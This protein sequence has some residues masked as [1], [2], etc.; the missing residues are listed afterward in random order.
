VKGDELAAMA[1][2][3]EAWEAAD[4]GG[5]HPAAADHHH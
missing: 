4:K 1:A 5:A 2:W 3:T